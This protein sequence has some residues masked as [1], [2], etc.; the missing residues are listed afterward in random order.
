MNKFSIEDNYQKYL[1]LNKLDENQMHPEQ[2]KQ[3][4]DAFFGAVGMILMVLKY[5]VTEL[6]PDEALIVLDDFET[7]VGA[8]FVRR[9]KKM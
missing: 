9:V 6:N 3:L 1:Q 4:R 2:K 5:D 7:Q 8:Y